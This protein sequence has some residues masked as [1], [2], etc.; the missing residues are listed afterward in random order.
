MRRD[1]V[2]YLLQH[3]V[4]FNK[5]KK[6]NFEPISENRIFGNGDRF[7]QND[8]VI[9]TRKGTKSCQDLSEPS[10]ESLYNSSGIGLYRSPISPI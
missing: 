7:N 5:Y 10:Q 2:I 8:F 9:D 1:T 4:F 3:L 6:I